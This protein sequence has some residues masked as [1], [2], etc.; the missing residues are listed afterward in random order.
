MLGTARVYLVLPIVGAAAVAVAT[1]CGG[2]GNTGSGG[3]G[4]MGGATSSS[5]SSTA[6]SSKASS[7]SSTGGGMMCPP[8]EG[9]TL[10]ITKLSFGEGTN[11]E[12]KKY[13]FNIDGKVSTG[14]ST[15]VCM[16]ADMGDPNVAFPDGD[17][18]NDNSFGKNLL[19]TIISVYPTWPA[20][21]NTA[22]TNGQF[23]TLLKM[24]CLPPKGDVTDMTTKLFGGTPLGM[25]PKFDGTDM[26]PVAP[27]LLSD[28]MD[29]ESSTI[30]FPKSSV[31]G[32]KFDSQPD[33]TFILTVPMQSQSRSAEIKLTLHAAHVTMD[34]SSDRKSATGGMIGGVLNTNEF[35]AEVKKIAWVFG[36]CSSSAYQAILTQV[37]QSSDIMTNGKPNPTK[38]CDGISIGLGFEMK[39]VQIGSVG[40]MTPLGMAC[41]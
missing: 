25:M 27:E 28:Q 40:P 17:N 7:S 4:G 35:I 38:T 29:P 12:W 10:A 34:L 9:V 39:E 18:G 26:W 6:S 33:Q 22:I 16:P 31:T 32:S 2:S 37:Q 24:Y 5:E 3:G 21:V 1:S 30:V 15:D 13:G 20:D 19:P 11:G 14:A 41:P 36:L 23:N 8:T